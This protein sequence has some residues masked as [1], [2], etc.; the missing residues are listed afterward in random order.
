M[1]SST[2]ILVTKTGILVG[3][4]V[5]H[6]KGWRFLP[7]C[8]THQPSRKYWPTANACIPKWAFDLSDEMLTAAEWEARKRQPTKR[9]A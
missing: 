3:T 7:N 1:T 5:E 2:M 4:C 9:C 6:P 8:S